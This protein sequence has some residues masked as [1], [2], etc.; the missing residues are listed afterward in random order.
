MIK[1][2]F[3]SN[4]LKND[5]IFIGTE[6]PMPLEA[7]TIKITIIEINHKVIS[8]IDLDKEKFYIIIQK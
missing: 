8:I 7:T 1:E 5:N 2:V 3:F 4:V 6:T